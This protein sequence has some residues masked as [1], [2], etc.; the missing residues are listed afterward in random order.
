ML[1]ETAEQLGYEVYGV[2]IGNASVDVL[3]NKFGFEHVFHGWFDQM[4]IECCGG[5]EF[6]DL[7]TMV[8]VLEHVR[9]PNNTLNQIS[10]VL[11]KGG[12]VACYIPNTSS[13]AA[14]ILGSRW[15]FYCTPHLF[16]FSA[17]NLK[18]LFEKHGFDVLASYPSP[19]YLSIEYA[20][21]VIQYELHGGLGELMLPILKRV[22]K[23]LAR[24][25]MPCYVGNL[26]IIV[27]KN[28]DHT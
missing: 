22:P 6:F 21:N 4:E 24:L 1:L 12:L 7:V 23:F 3:R 9:N 13:W 5:A 8:D 14:K 11:K 18:A 2:E 28:D 27:Q 25:I 15:E 20:R 10:K 17:R 16:A 26:T 19:R